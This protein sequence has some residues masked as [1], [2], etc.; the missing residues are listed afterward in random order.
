M[1]E[2]HILI[3]GALVD[4]SRAQDV[5][6]KRKARSIAEAG[7]RIC[8]VEIALVDSAV[9]WRAVFE[10]GKRLVWTLGWR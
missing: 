6:V 8:S 10:P 9:V 2:W 4:I 7:G 1:R 3:D 5:A